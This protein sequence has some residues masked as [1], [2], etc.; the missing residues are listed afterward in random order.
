MQFLLV[1]SP[2][3][4]DW[5]HKAIQRMANLAVMARHLFGGVW[6]VAAQSRIES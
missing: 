5:L 1:A 4:R 3:P 2:L 6:W